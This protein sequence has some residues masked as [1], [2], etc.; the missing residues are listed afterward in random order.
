[1]NQL[2][3]LTSKL[4]GR[5]L[6]WIRRDALFHSCKPQGDFFAEGPVQ[7]PRLFASCQLPGFIRVVILI[8]ITDFSL[9]QSRV[10]S[11]CKQLASGAKNS[12]KNE[13]EKE[14]IQYAI[15]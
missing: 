12:S 1:M 3:H 15:I 2:R 13:S 14:K 4:I 11:S 8:T 7:P 5:T 9:T 6:S 10:V